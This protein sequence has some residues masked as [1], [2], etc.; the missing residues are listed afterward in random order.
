MEASSAP[1][2]FVGLGG[3]SWSL[4]GANRGE[5]IAAFVLLTFTRMPSLSPRKAPLL[6]GT[7][8]GR[9]LVVPLPRPQVPHSLRDTNFEITTFWLSC[10]IT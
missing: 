8:D 3:T 1:E 10:K 7:K 4:T 5:A 2:S 6:E 9:H